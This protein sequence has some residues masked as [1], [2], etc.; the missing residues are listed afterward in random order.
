MRHVGVIARKLTSQLQSILENLKLQK[1]KAE[2]ELVKEQGAAGS[3][4]FDTDDPELNQHI[5]SHSL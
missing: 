2:E 1:V 4:A 3:S 5:V